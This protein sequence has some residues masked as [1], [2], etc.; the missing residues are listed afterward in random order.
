MATSTPVFPVSTVVVCRACGSPARADQIYCTACQ[1]A[2]QKACD[3]PIPAHPMLTCDV[4][5]ASQEL[6]RRARVSRADLPP[7]AFDS[8]NETLYRHRRNAA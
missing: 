4:L 6:T 2:I 5:W 1:R 8:L 7:D 3:R